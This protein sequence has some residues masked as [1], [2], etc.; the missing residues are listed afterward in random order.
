MKIA[1]IIPTYNERENILSLLGQ[2][3]GAT[4]PLRQHQFTFVVVDDRSPDGTADVVNAYRKKN[5]H[6]ELITGKKEGLGKALLRGMMYAI[7]T[8]G[9]DA[10]AQID[11][12]L[13]HD[14]SVFPRF[15]AALDG[16]SDFVIGS[17]YI[18]GGSIPENWGLHRKIY[19]VLGN[20]IVR[21]GLGFSSVHDWTGGYRLYLRSYAERLR[22]EMGMYRG[23]VFQ[24]AFLYK[25]ILLGA[26]V[27]EVPIHFTDRRF[28]HSKIAPSEYI[29]DV[30]IFVLRQRIKRLL[31]GSFFKFCV[32]GTIGFIIN[33]IVLEAAVRSGFHPAVGSAVG[34]EL[35]IIS[36][37]FLNN[38]WT[39]GNRKIIGAKIVGKFLQFNSTSIGAILL[40][41]GTVFV[42]THLLGIST[43]RWFY[44]LGVGF[45]LM[46]NYIMYSKVI[47]RK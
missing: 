20:A 3:A 44:V 11:G 16:G 29:R 12:D 34:A 41:A 39:F 40:Q 32:V 38:A 7:D 9:A 43:Y 27:V 21:F 31:Y 42:G 30:L 35:A 14:P 19:S 8:L 5:P 1:V 36:N 28:G 22:K 4:R 15:V 23:Y 45:G 6:T 24:I 47:W 25:S 46:W 37:F 13:S 33:T 26:D 17:R 18:A 10:I 2:L